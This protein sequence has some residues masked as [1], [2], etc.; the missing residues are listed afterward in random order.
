M[1]RATYVTA[2]ARD[3]HE[4]AAA[5]A[6]AREAQWQARLGRMRAERQ[7]AAERQAALEVFVGPLPLPCSRTAHSL[8]SVLPSRLLPGRIHMPAEQR[9]GVLNRGCMQL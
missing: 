8:T 9:S 3:A 7:E 6:E 5:A 4:C 2:E 1:P